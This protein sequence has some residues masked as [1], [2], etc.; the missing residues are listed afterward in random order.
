MK[1]TS[2]LKE[3]VNLPTQ[4]PLCHRYGHKK[5]TGIFKDC[6]FLLRSGEVMKV[7]FERMIAKSHDY[8]YNVRRL[9][10]PSSMSPALQ[11]RKSRFS[12]VGVT[13]MWYY[14]TKDGH[15]HK[16]EE[17]TNWV[18]NKFITNCFCLVIWSFF[19]HIRLFFLKDDLLN[20][21][22]SHVFFCLARIRPMLH[23]LVTGLKHT[24]L[25]A[26]IHERLLVWL[27]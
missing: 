18:P 1:R 25:K 2:T 7:N 23:W 5:R 3:N 21:S 15:W 8:K 6:H 16:F 26:Q 13:W 14:Q 22:L 4:F 12:P 20:N 19:L 24:I 10:T 27:K 17:V 9:S 11:K